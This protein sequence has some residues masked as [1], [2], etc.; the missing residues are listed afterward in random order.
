MSNANFDTK[1]KNL[2]NDK[3]TYV[4][5]P[6]SDFPTYGG[7]DTNFTLKECENACD[8]TDNCYA[9]FN[10]FNRCLLYNSNLDSS[11]IDYNL[12]IKYI[13]CH[14]NEL[15]SN[16]LPLN[17]SGEFYNGKDFYV[18]TNY[19]KKNKNKF[20]YLNTELDI[21]KSLTKNL[22]NFNEKKNELANTINPQTRE[23]LTT[24]YNNILNN[25]NN[26]GNLFGLSRNY[27]NSDLID[28]SY[29]I[30]F[31]SNELDNE[32]DLIYADYITK[33]DDKIK[34]NDSLNQQQV[35]TK[36]SFTTTFLYYIVLALIMTIT[37]ATIIIY[38]M[39]PGI[40]NDL[41]IFALL[42][43]IVVLMYFLHFILKI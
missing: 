13:S 43:G 40:I 27:L 38:V 20:E 39:V 2:C 41:T 23:D 35:T 25:I 32:T 24:I 29:S 28:T 5:F 10:M 7:G 31:S 1:Y 6:L 18:N 8:S 26:I 19:Y 22:H 42:I 37:I 17:L 30:N 15:S 21:V 4:Y 34:T 3:S 14:G 12:D 16:L 33:L 36:R 9:F 11:G